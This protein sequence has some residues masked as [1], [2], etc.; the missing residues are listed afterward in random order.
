MTLTPPIGYFGSKIRMA[1]EIVDL[2]PG[3][4]GYIEPFAGSLSVLLAKPPVQMEVVNDLDRDLMTFWQVLRDRPEDLIR[5]CRLTPH[6]RAEYAACWPIVGE[7]DDLERARRVWVKL[8]HGR[9]GT[10][11]PTGW[12]NQE[13]PTGRSSS[14]PRSM[15]GFVARMEA[16]A[17]RLTEVTLECLPALEIIERYGRA[18]TS[19]L[20]VDPPYLLDTR[21]ANYR[22]E[23]G[24]QEQHR[25]LARALASCKATVVL[26]G[27]PHPLYDEDL[28][29]GWDRIEIAAATGQNA[30][31]GWQERT[32]V[33]W[34][35]R[36][37][38]RDDPLFEVAS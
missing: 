33:L 4:R 18:Q 36:R 35:N 26:S 3:H 14:V 6:S 1:P 24:E 34:C 22:H 32:E 9:N 20:Y 27:Y 19:M 10:L 15:Q 21:G 25:E 8:S 17:S 28:Y 23:M 11:R 12:R 29:A 7:I 30:D 16:V 5:A 38:R 37:L 2:L 13:S 31:A